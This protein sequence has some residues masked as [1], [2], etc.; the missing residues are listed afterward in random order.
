MYLEHRTYLERLG[1]FEA[2]F[3][4]CSKHAET[5]MAAFMGVALS[6]SLHPPL[7]KLYP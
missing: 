6:E 7:T 3:F 1:S 4:T 5:L 2:S